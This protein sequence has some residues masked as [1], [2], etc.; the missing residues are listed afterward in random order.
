MER[1]KT[2]MVLVSLEREKSSQ[3]VHNS[4]RMGKGLG[5]TGREG[6][7]GGELPGDHYFL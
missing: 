6:C 3:E 1:R 2:R 4:T 7:E 5:R